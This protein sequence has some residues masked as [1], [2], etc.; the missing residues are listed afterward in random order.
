MKEQFP[1]LRLAKEEDYLH[2]WKIWMQEHIIRWMSFPPMNQDD[3]YDRYHKLAQQRRIKYLKGKYSHVAEFCSM[4]IDEKRLRNKYGQ[5]F[6]E[7]FE[8]IVAEK[9]IKRI[10]LTQSGGNNAAFSLSD[11]YEYQVEAVFPDWLEREGKQQ[12]YHFVLERF[13]YKFVD[14]ELQ[15]Q[16]NNIG[17]LKY[18]A[19][20]PALMPN[21]FEKQL[22]VTL[23]A[24]RF[25]VLNENSL[26]VIEFEYYPDDSVIQH[27][28][29]LDNM[30]LYSKDMDLCGAALR[31]ALAYIC[32]NEKVKKLE[33]FTHEPETVALCQRLGFWVRGERLASCQING[34]FYNELGVEYSYLGIT[35]AINFI[36][37]FNADSNNGLKEALLACR[38][39]IS[40]L[41]DSKECDILGSRYL[42]NIVYQMVRDSHQERNYSALCQ[43]PWQEVIKQCPE[44]FQ[45]AL[46]SLNKTLQKTVPFQKTCSLPSPFFDS[47]GKE[48]G[49]PK[50]QEVTVT[51][52]TLRGSVL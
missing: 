36:K 25:C 6:T 32:E 42:E 52:V 33:L 21:S 37:S 39:V 22:T 48:G 51:P 5:R 34:N 3:F 47:V 44:V 26:P 4:G 20:L 10:Q 15:R 31:K 12:S 41:M 9:G 27:I 18:N 23:K 50:N 49:M 29:F 30:V 38:E 45:L 28:G 35:E 2:I 17:T 46:Q 24:G 43:Q 16:I 13:I 11:K 8:K 40:N 14:K 1:Y 7:E 19:K